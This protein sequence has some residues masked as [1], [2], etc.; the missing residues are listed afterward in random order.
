MLYKARQNPFLNINLEPDIFIF[1]EIAM[2]RAL[3]GF[4]QK[5]P[6]NCLGRQLIVGTVKSQCRSWKT[7][8]SLLGSL[9][10]IRNRPGYNFESFTEQ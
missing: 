1:A 10:Q 3:I 8:V 9:P 4:P 2:D 7:L 6:N 5:N